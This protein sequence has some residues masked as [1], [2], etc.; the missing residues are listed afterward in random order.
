MLEILYFAIGLSGNSECVET[1]NEIGY[2]AAGTY[3]LNENRLLPGFIANG[4][5][6][7]NGFTIDSISYEETSVEVS[8]G[9]RKY[10][11]ILSGFKYE[12]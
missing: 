4:C 3:Y 6:M 8:N 7:D 9:S 12:N 1:I 2:A 11:L 10:K 5:T